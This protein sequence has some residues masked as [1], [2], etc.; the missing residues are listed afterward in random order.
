M[1]LAGLKPAAIICEIMNDDGTMTKGGDLN[2]F[3]VNNGL[4]ILSIEEVY[5]AAY[6]E[7]L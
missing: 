1:K 4:S 3:A 2:K 5:E 7:S 6:N